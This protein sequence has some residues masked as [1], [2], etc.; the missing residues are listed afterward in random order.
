VTFIDKIWHL[1][2]QG[3][4]CLVCLGAAIKGSSSTRC[5][6]VCAA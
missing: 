1:L 6:G 2:K 3:S 5:H 4:P